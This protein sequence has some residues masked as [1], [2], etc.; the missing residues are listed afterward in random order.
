MTRAYFGNAGRDPEMEVSL[1]CIGL[2]MQR[3]KGA[4]RLDGLLVKPGLILLDQGQ[5]RRH[6]VPSKGSQT[7][8]C[9]YEENVQCAAGSSG[10]LKLVELPSGH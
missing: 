9:T 1:T 10:R 8:D 7:I 4:D 5:E 2:I 6:L 3:E